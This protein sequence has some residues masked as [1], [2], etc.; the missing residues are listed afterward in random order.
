MIEKGTQK[1]DDTSRHIIYIYIYHG[2]NV[3][4]AL[5]EKRAKDLVL[6]LNEIMNQLAI[7]DSVHWYGHVLREE[8]CDVLRKALEF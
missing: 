7:I 8:E 6:G 2:K 5:I 1:V 3:H 4:S